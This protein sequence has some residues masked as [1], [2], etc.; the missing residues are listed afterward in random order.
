MSKSAVQLLFSQEQLLQ[1]AGAV[2]VEPSIALT[3]EADTAPGDHGIA[4]TE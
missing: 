2:K 1:D 3:E 4:E